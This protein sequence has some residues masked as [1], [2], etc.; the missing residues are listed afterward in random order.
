MKIILL[1]FFYLS[2]GT[3]MAQEKRSQE[4]FNL[5]G[6]II[7]RDTGFIYLRY[8]NANGKDVIDT[9]RLDKGSFK[10]KGTLNGATKASLRGLTKSS[11]VEDPNATSIYL[12][13][14]EIEVKLKEND[15]KNAK[16]KGSKTQLEAETLEN[17]KKVRY[18]QKEELNDRIK[19]L[20]KVVKNGDTLIGTTDKLRTARSDY[21][22]ITERI[23][24]IDYEFIQGHPSS[25]LSSYMLNLY[26]SSRKISLDSTENLFNK[27]TVKNR[28]ST[29]GEVLN[30]AIKSRKASVVG[31]SAPLFSL[32]NVNGE[33]LKLVDFRKKNYV[34]LDFWASWCIP[35]L[36]NIPRLKSIYQK[37]NQMGLDVVSIS[38][39]TD[40]KAWLKAVDNEK[41]PWHQVLDPVP[42]QEGG[43]MTNYAVPSIPLL[44]LVDKQG[45]IIGRYE[46]GLTSELEKKLSE[47]LK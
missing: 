12:E 9:D 24:Q 18:S 32:P 43:Q 34:L 10:F 44:L 5:Q 25:Y 36:E 30:K 46:N 11:S 1:L 39:D 47:I 8:L 14:A 37:Y 4:S 23:K 41:M 26:F 38:V 2:F 22:S 6:H 7:G 31:A 15:F 21:A 45:T 17:S 27:F 33:Q 28:T 3:A 35:C 20:A 19:G 42:F 40:K 13:N 16:I 29:I